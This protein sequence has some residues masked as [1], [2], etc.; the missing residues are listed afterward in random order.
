MAKRRNGRISPV[1]S[2]VLSE[3]IALIGSEESLQVGFISFQKG[4]EP[5]PS[6]TFEDEVKRNPRDA[7]L[8]RENRAKLLQKQ[9]EEEEARKL[10]IEAKHIRER[11]RLCRVRRVG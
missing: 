5:L 1:E 7:L 3:S 6:P 8:N 9:G 4:F 2:A 10:L 11:M